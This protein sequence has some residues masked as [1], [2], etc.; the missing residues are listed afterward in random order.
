MIELII[1]KFLLS[2]S[3]Y[4]KYR[5]SLRIRKEDR[6]LL[7]LYKVLDSL[8]DKYNRDITF[9]EF[10]LAVLTEYPEHAELIEQISATDIGEDM[11]ADMVKQAI[12]RSLAHDL[13][14]LSIDVS[15]GR[16]PLPDLLNFFPKFDEKK[17]VD[18]KAE[19]V[20]DDVEELYQ[21]TK[22]KPGLRWRLKALNQALGSLR[23]GDFGFLF[24]RPETGKTTFL[25]EEV[26]FMAQQ[27][28]EDAGPILWFNN[29]EGGMK[30]KV[31]IMQASLG[32]TNNRLFEDRKRAQEE[33]MKRTKGKIL[34]KD[35]AT[36]SRRE[37]ER[38]CKEL[39]PSLIIFDQIDKI[40]GFDDDRE[41][42]RLGAIYIWARELAKTY[43]P[44]IGVCQADVSGE[45]KKY[46]TMDNVAN[47][48]TS[49]QA[50]ADWILG[51]GAVHDEGLKY[52]RYLC[53]SKNKLTGDDD[54]V[55]EMRHGKME[56]LIQ[57]DIARYKDIN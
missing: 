28:A 21:E 1:L 18:E 31:R 43:C 34:L 17:E 48:K 30:V 35:S 41:D 49:K 26:T 45:N 2:V 36:I 53:V 15:E 24:A 9:P 16:R 42:L 40:K 12:E 4:T 13:A 8:H 19:F 20:T 51:I 7:A 22:H 55:P 47:A 57:P 46:L 10:R 54:S 29:E 11:L 6:E 37:I 52:M 33:Y 23:K 50:E 38:L 27:L 14:L 44:V 56:V 3:N 32:C 5:D 25:A 39:K